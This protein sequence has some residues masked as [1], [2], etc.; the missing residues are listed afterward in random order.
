M[1][2]LATVAEGRSRVADILVVDDDADLAEVISDLLHDAGHTVRTAHDGED[3]L[4]L[5]AERH[6]DL[7][8]LDVEMPLLTGPEMSHRMLVHDLGEED[9][10]LILMSGVTN[11][12][13]VA[14]LVGTP[15]FLPKPYD[16]TA[17]TRLVDWV[18]IERHPPR[19]KP[20]EAASTGPEGGP[21]RPHG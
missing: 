2:L 18:L 17:L 9:I 10:P 20:D 6:P 15:Y 3:G 13:K 8:L 14:E 1:T 12:F 11:L 19:P 7:V 21:G 5:I 16:L 4:R